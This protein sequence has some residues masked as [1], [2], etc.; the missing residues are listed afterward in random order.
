MLRAIVLLAS[1]VAGGVAQSFQAG[2][3]L[4]DLGVYKTAEACEARSSRPCA[5]SP[6]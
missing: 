3:G 6:G 1:A 4:S 5:P 2:D